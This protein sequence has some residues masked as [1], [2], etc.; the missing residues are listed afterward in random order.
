MK[1]FHKH[2]YVE[3]AFKRFI[4]KSYTGMEKFQKY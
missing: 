4:V 3:Q 1:M 2:G